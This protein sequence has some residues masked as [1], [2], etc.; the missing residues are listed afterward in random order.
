MDRKGEE[1]KKRGKRIVISVTPGPKSP[2][3][4]AAA[5]G[6]IASTT[7]LAVARISVSVVAVPAPA[8][9]P[10]ACAAMVSDLRPCVP[11]SSYPHL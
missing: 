9:V 5:S 7:Q 3:L 10:T 2:G 8:A 6:R 11:R 4:T 1:C